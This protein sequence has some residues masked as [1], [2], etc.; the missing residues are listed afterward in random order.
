MT[1]TEQVITNRAT[2]I[3]AGAA[4]TLVAIFVLVAVRPVQES[5]L[6]RAARSWSPGHGPD[7]PPRMIDAGSMHRHGFEELY[8]HET[9][10]KRAHVVSASSEWRSRERRLQFSSRVHVRLNQRVTLPH[11]DRS[12]AARVPVA[13]EATPSGLPFARNCAQIATED[14]VAIYGSSACVYVEAKLTE[15][16]GSDESGHAKVLGVALDARDSL[17]VESCARSSMSRA[18]GCLLA[19]EG[20][21]SIGAA[22]VAQMGFLHGDP[23][24]FDL[25]EWAVARAWAVGR[26]DDVPS[27]KLTKDGRTILLP[28]AAMQA[29]IDGE[30]HELGDCVAEKDGRWLVPATIDGLAQ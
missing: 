6:E 18:I 2:K 24:Y 14:R 29:K 10:G 26:P 9:G 1:R 23:S 4:A 28:L 5:A 21:R 25:V 27:V 7:P 17:F 22:E 30:W 11:G 19:S 3:L 16:V 15:Y 8:S 20:T 12:F 13:S